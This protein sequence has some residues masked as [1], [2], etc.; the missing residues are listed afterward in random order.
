ME[1][2]RPPGKP[3]RSATACQRMPNLSS[4]SSSASVSAR[5]HPGSGGTALARAIVAF[6]L[7][8]ECGHLLVGVPFW[9]VL[10]AGRA[11]WGDRF[12]R[13]SLSIGSILVALGGLYFLIAALRQYS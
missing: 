13:Q 1:R 10:R 6:C 4:N 7:G 2:G 8:V 12:A 3:H 11:E 9:S 5:D